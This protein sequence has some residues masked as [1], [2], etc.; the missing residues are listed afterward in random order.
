M[1]KNNSIKKDYENRFGRGS[2]E[3]PKIIAIGLDLEKLYA[4]CLNE[5][6]TWQQLLIKPNIKY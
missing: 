3:I 6:K 1:N 4:R 5:N 2:S